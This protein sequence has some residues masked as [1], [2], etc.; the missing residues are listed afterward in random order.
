MDVIL[1]LPLHHLFFV[2]QTAV[3]QIVDGLG[4]FWGVV[5][6]DGHFPQAFLFF[7]HIA[8]VYQNVFFRQP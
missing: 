5:T 1:V 2:E 8:E 4:D 3:V 7:I 6:L